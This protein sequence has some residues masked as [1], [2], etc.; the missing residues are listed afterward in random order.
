MTDYRRRR[1][2]HITSPNILRS[3]GALGQTTWCFMVFYLPGTNPIQRFHHCALLTVPTSS[4]LN[5]LRLN[6]AASCR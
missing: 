3:R 1:L 2:R 4:S 6:F 5:G